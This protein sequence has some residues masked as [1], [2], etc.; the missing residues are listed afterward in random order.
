MEADRLTWLIKLTN[1]C[2][3]ALSELEHSG[4]P[5]H[6]PLIEDI[7]QLRQRLQTELD[8]AAGS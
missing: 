4:D 6:L 1:A 5:L 8:G 7:Q 3:Q 2:D